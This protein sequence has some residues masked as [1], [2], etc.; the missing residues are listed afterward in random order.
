MEGHIHSIET[1]GLVDGPGIRFVVFMQGCPLRCLFCHNPETWEVTGGITMTAQELVKKITKYRH[2]YYDG[3][4]VTFSGGEPLLQYDFL[5]EAFRLCK[6]VNIHTCLDTSGVGKVDLDLLQYVDLVLLDIKAIDSVNYQK[7]TGKPM[8]AFQHFIQLCQQ[9]N[10]KIWI[11]QV[12][13][14]NINDNR[15][16]IKHLADYINGLKNIEK[17][18]FLPYHLLGIH[19]YEELGIPYPLKNVE[20]MNT[21]ACEKLYRYFESLWKPNEN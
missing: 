9:L 15:E 19:K 4:G 21:D 18:E 16:Y 7:M 11:R 10:K 5:K 17:V 2:Y 14:P 6:V 20:A 12:I 13:V 3:G 8:S 1:M